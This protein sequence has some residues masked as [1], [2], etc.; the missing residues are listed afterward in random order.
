ML[1]KFAREVMIVKKFIEMVTI[2]QGTQM[3]VADKIYLQFKL[4]TF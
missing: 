2:D 4:F 3:Y 1:I